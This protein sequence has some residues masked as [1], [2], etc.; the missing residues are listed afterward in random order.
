MNP[1]VK[2]TTIRL[3]RGLI[4]ILI[5]GLVSTYKNNPLYLALAPA[6]SALGKFLRLK[7]GV[8]NVPF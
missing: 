2:A 5:A 1:I 7:W 4:T 6:L 8:K 3:G